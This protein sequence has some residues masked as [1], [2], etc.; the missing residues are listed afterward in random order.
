MN[1]MGHNQGPDAAEALRQRLEERFGP[2]VE[3]RDELLEAFE[4]APETMGDDAT[5]GRTGDFIKQLAAAVKDAETHRKAEKEPF[6]N[7]GRTVDGW[8]KGISEPL[9]AAQKV[10]TTRLTVYERAKA[11]EERK[12]R[13]AEEAAAR[14]EAEAAIAEAKERAAIV[15]NDA[16]LD[17]AIQ[18]EEAAALAR[19][20]AQDAKKEAEA[21]AAELS[22][23]RGDLGSVASLRTAWVGELTD[24][25]TLDLEALRQHLSEDALEKAIR[26]YVKAGGRELPGAQI[27]ERTT[28]VVR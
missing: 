17:A 14:A 27:E 3:R 6:L 11:A 23:T 9:Q 19:A 28:T 25:A 7:S 20:A 22:R 4:R 21:N 18:A 1:D 16:D 13:E 8:F 12:R 26:A 10:M 5:A 2:N 24:R 15:K